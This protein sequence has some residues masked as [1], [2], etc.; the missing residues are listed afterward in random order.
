[1][2]SEKASGALRE[3]AP[4]A[5]RW[6][7]HTSP[8]AQFLAFRCGLAAVVFAALVAATQA[9]SAQTLTTLHS[10]SGPPD[11][12]TPVAGLVLDPSGNLYGTTSSGGV[13]NKACANGCGTVFKVTPAGNESVMYNF[14]G[15][16]KKITNDGADPQSGLIFDQQGNLYGTTSAGG[17]FNKGNGTVFKVT[18]SGVETMI[19]SFAGENHGDGT[20]PVAGLVMD[21]Q[22]NFYGTTSAGGGYNKG[23][24]FKVTPSGLETILYSFEPHDSHYPAAGLILDAQGNFYGTTPWGEDGF[25]GRTGCGTV[26]KV[27]PSGVETIL[28]NFQAR[29]KDGVHSVAG[30]LWDAQGNLYGTTEEGGAHE[31]GAVFELTA[32]GTETVLYSFT[33]GDDG[34]SP[35]AGLIFDPQG[36][37]YGTTA[38]GGLYGS[39]T[40]FELTPAGTET[41]LYNFTGGDDG[42]T[43]VAGLVFDTQANL[44]GTTRSGGAYNLGTVFKLVP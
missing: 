11:G 35:A 28:Y 3:Q 38:G 44:Y 41:V 6:H 10:F 16:Y 26:F 22:G 5:A 9:A 21:S 8:T 36:N 31:F 20:S 42:A 25:C 24:V 15:K 33:G 27:S 2:I 18:R 29:Q 32:T 34:A 4:V 1:M 14:I 39:G 23:T 30:L 12:S 7:E 43:P 19:Y 40:I 13:I 17:S 37:L